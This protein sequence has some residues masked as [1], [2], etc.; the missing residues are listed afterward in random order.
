MH[1]RHHR[2]FAI[3]FG[4]KFLGFVRDQELHQRLRIGRIRRVRRQR[5]AGDVDVRAAVSRV[6]E[7]HFDGVGPW[8]LLGRFLHRHH[9]VGVADGDVAQPGLHVAH[10]LAVAA[11]GLARQIV[12]D[13]GQPGFGF[14][15][16]EVRDHRRDERDVI[17]VLTRADA[18]FAA[19]LRVGEFFVG[20]RRLLH[21]IFGGVDDA[22]AARQANPVAGGIAELSRHLLVDDRRI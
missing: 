22:G 1:A 8:L 20:D 2:I 9:V 10:L 7:N 15:L 14:F 16:A 4:V 5:H 19:P 21:A 18:D 3:G 13:A 12:F 6:R 17:G 11:S